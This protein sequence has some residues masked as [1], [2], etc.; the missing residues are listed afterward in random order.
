MEM[1]RHFENIFAYSDHSVQFVLALRNC[2]QGMLSF[3]DFLWQEPYSKYECVSVGLS[4][5]FVNMHDLWRYV[6]TS[7]NTISV[8]EYCVVRAYERYIHIFL[9]N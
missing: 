5:S 3:V 8:F 2:E 7:K 1:M 9:Q 6:T 4:Y